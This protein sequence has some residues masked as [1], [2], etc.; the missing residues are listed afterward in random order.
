MQNPSAPPIFLA[1]SSPYR[2]GLLDRFL[3]EYEAISPEVDE[4]NEEGL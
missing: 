4:S 3:A 1:S 2:R